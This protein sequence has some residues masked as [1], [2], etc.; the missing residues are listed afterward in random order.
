MGELILL[1][2]G[3]TE[4]SAAG[5]HTGRTDVPL[6]AKGVADAVALV[7]EVTRMIA[8][9]RVAAVFASPAQRAQRTAVLAGLTMAKTDPDLWE[10]DYGGYEGIT[11]AE[12]QRGRPG[13]SLWRDGIIPGDAA[14]P[15]ES[16]A[17]VGERADLVIERAAPLLTDGGVVLVAHGHLL[18]ILTARW[19]GLPPADG[20][21]FRLDTGTVSTLG[22]E[23]GEQ[24]I[25][26]WN[27]PPAT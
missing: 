18:R 22:T 10:W 21:L 20:R 6:T 26:T 12:I 23:H 2:H 16:V 3:Q 17:S 19:L 7:P 5:R 25:H 24:V 27:V 14:H 4:W 11:T 15:G 13:W 9:G 1:R 8:D